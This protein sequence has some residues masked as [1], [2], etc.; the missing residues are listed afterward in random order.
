ML[1]DSNSCGARTIRAVR[2]MRQSVRA[3]RRHLH[4]AKLW[5]YMISTPN[6]QREP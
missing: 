6:D 3:L 2:Y 1:H 4:N 5:V